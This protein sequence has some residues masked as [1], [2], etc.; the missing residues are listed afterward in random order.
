MYAFDSVHEK[1]EVSIDPVPESLQSYP[2]P[3]LAGR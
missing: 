2:C 3:G 1:F